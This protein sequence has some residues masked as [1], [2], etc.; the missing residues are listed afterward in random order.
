MG[1]VFGKCLA[2]FQVLDI[3]KRLSLKFKTS[4]LFVKHRKSVNPVFD[5]P[6]LW[7]KWLLE[8]ATIP[9]L[10]MQLAQHDPIFD[11]GI[12][13]ELQPQISSRFFQKL[14]LFSFPFEGEAESKRKPGT[15]RKVHLMNYSLSYSKMLS[16]EYSHVS[17]RFFPQQKKQC[18]HRFWSKIQQHQ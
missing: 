16:P 8:D 13:W 11:N 14:G 15:L 7:A 4:P 18:K 6:Y 1:Y 12:M 17:S 9:P 3:I 5:L 10:H 2:G